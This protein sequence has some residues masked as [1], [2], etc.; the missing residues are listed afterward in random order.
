MRTTP[1]WEEG[2]IREH[3]LIANDPL[4]EAEARE[5]AHVGTAP[6]L[7]ALQRR[8]G[9][10]SLTRQK[11]LINAACKVWSRQH[12]G[13]TPGNQH[14]MTYPVYRHTHKALHTQPTHV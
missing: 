11:K 8:G 3:K 1:R 4:P 6:E 5:L 7:A 12:L 2:E 14:S 10:H 13:F 9:G